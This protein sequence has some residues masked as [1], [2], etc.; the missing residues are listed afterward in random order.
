MALSSL[1]QMGD[2]SAYGP[3]V[4]KGPGLDAWNSAKDKS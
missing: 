1:E 2:K 4:M 3:I